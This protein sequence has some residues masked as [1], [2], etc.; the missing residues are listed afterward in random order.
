[1]IKQCMALM[2]Y[3]LICINVDPVPV[4]DGFTSLFN[5]KNLEGWIIQGFEKAQPKI[6]EGIMEV[7]G[8]DYWAVISQKEF[9]NFVLNFEF[10]L[11]KKGNS[12]LIIHAPK[13]EIYKDKKFLVEIQLID[14]EFQQ[15]RNK[16][17]TEF[18]GAIF[19]KVPPLKP[20]ELKEWNQAKI[21]CADSKVWVMIN[22]TLLQNG[23]PVQSRGKGRIAFQRD[24]NMKGA[25]FRNIIIKEE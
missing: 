10:K 17:R 8:W 3:L 1:M 20:V 24:E 5:G 4:E 11:E 16:P 12:G 2:F 19:G 23:T 14:D 7:T 6:R 22:G 13:K 21:K 9:S 15:A 25:L 18:T